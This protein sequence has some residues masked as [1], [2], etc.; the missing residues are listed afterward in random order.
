MQ[1]VRKSV[2]TS[3][4]RL[5]FIVILLDVKKP[6]SVQRSSGGPRV[7]A[8]GAEGEVIFG[9][10]A[11]VAVSLDGDVN[12]G[13]LLQELCIALQ[14]S[15]LVRAHIVLV[16]IEVNV[17]YVAREQF[18]FRGVGSRWRRFCGRVHGDASGGFLG[19]AGSFCDEMV[20]G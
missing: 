6:L 10:A 17:L 20:G 4:T 8:I 15:L 16:V 19:A 1:R 18:L 7:P 12:V 14:R 13:V 9:R 5:D 2:R 11:L 3:G